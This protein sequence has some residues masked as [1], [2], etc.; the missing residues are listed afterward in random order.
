M[1]AWARRKDVQREVANVPDNWLVGFA[2]A[3]PDD[4]RKL[5]EAGSTA[6]LLYRSSAVIEAVE[7]GEFYGKEGGAS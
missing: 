7:R 4:V 2:V 3:H 1:I 6:T 5:G